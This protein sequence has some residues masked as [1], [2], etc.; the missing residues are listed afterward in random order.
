MQLSRDSLQSRVGSAVRFVAFHKLK[1][2]CTLKKV[3]GTQSAAEVSMLRLK[4]FRQSALLFE[5]LMLLLD[6]LVQSLRRSAAATATAA[7]AG[8]AA[9][10]AVGG[11]SS[12][13]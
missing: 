3:S 2:Q 13:G 8:T 9:S 4:L 12:G 6:L 7:A 11:S 1:L 5:L 10:T